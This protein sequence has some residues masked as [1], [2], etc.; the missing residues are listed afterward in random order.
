[1]RVVAQGHCHS[2]VC[3][4]T[5]P[6]ALFNVRCPPPPKSW[7]QAIRG[8]SEWRRVE[9]AFAVACHQRFSRPQASERLH[10][11]AVSFM[12]GGAAHPYHES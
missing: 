11:L 5:S 3:Q 2:T 4:D 8:T 7:C 9:L 12:I 1:M 10:T 6:T